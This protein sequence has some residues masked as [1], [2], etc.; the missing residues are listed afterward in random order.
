MVEM[1]AILILRCQWPCCVYKK[2]C[3]KRYKDIYTD[4]Q[5]WRYFV[6]IYYITIYIRL[7]SAWIMVLVALVRRNRHL[8]IYRHHFIYTHLS[9]DCCVGKTMLLLVRE[10][11]YTRMSRRINVY[12]YSPYIIVA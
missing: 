8:F 12:A 9:G 10:V 1:L 2:S 3:W 7:R 11:T 6:S 5:R 4:R